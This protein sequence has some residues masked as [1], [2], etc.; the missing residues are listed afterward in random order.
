MLLFVVLVF[1]KHTIM[2]VSSLEEERTVKKE[3]HR[4]KPNSSSYVVKCSDVFGFLEKECANT[5][6]LILDIVSSFVDCCWI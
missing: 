2:C 6:F 4:K 3:E 1:Q 5:C